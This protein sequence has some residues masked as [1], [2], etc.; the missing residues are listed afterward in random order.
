MYSYAVGEEVQVRNFGLWQIGVFIQVNLDGKLKV[1]IGRK[2]IV[3]ANFY[4]VKP[5]Q[6][7]YQKMEKVERT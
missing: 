2:E 4:D 6:P 3:D 5:N 1:K 7:A